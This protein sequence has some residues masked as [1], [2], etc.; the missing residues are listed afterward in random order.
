LELLQAISIKFKELTLNL[1]LAFVT[2]GILLNSIKEE[3]TTVNQ[4]RF[5]AFAIGAISTGILLLLGFF[6]LSI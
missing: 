6:W 1:L 2:G 5:W 3:I 4:S